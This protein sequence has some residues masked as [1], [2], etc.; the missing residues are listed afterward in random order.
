MTPP[1]HCPRESLHN[2]QQEQ[3]QF[4]T[5]SLLLL[6]E[7]DTQFECYQES[8]ASDDVLNVSFFEGS[9]VYSNYGM[10]LHS[11]SMKP[12]ALISSNES[13]NDF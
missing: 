8:S 3:P 10:F 2:L 4:A 12:Q 13:S 9:K 1:Q 7:N 6:G 11:L 5:M